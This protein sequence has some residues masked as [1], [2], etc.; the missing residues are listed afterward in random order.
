MF[1]KSR[2]FLLGASAAAFVGSAGHAQEVGSPPAP[3]Q[4]PAQE[5]ADSAAA[6]SA[7]DPIV[8]MGT[9]LRGEVESDIPPEVELG[10]DDIAAYGATSIEEL[11]DALGPQTGSA[12]GRGG[13]GRP[14][15]LLN[16][17]RISGFRELRD[18]PPE[19]IER[20]QVFPEELALEYGYRPDQRVVNFIL[21]ENFA[22]ITGELETGMPTSGGYAEGEIEAT[23]TRITGG[24]RL[25]VDVEY[26]PVTALTEAERDI[27]QD[28]PDEL[29]LV[30]EG[31]F[32]TLI[33]ESDTLEANAS[34]SGQLSPA[35][36]LSLSGEYEHAE[37]R[38]LQGL[39]GADLTVPADSPFAR[40]DEDETV[41]RL[42]PAAGALNRSVNSDSAEAGLALNGSLGDYRWS[43]TGNY[44]RTERET[45]TERQAGTDEIAA[46]V[47]AGDPSVD[48]FDPALGAGLEFTADRTDS[49]TQGADAS[50]NISG[51]P[52]TLPAGDVR[53]SATAGYD[54]Q[55]IEGTS[56]RSGTVTE[57]DLSRS[58]AFIRGNADIPIT[59]VRDDVLAGIGDLSVNLNAG[60]RELSDFGGLTEY[61]YGLRWEPVEDISF[62]ASVIGE[63]AAPSLSQLGDP[64]IV[65]PN[66]R[67]F[68]IARGETVLIDQTTGGNPNLPAEDRRDLK[69]TLNWNPGGER[70]RQFTVEYVRN[71]S[72][73]V[74]SSFPLLT[75]AIEAA[76][77]GRVTRAAD[78]TLIA[79]DARPVAFSE[80][81][82]E[83]LRY[84]INLRGSFGEDEEEGGRGRRGQRGDGPPDPSRM[85]GRGGPSGGRWSFSIFHNWSLEETVLIRDGVPELDL[86]GGDAIAG[87]P[88]ARHSVEAE[89]GVFWNGFGLRADA[90]YTGSARVDG[91]ELPGATDLFYGDLYT[92]D[93][94]LFANLDQQQSLVEAVPFLAG[95]RLSLDIENVFGGIR[96]VEDSTGEVPLSFQPAYLDPQGRFIELSFRK[97]F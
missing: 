25:N 71:H 48:P 75:P 45:V 83:R 28:Q 91:S 34:W 81:D 38:S 19:A 17:Q 26:R 42:F 64:V 82:A 32:R 94:R 54:W 46:A 68:D 16:G 90:N 1:L 39:A 59:S 51:A 56:A 57:T 84:G 53:L 73:N 92:L 22:Q 12:R 14:V 88:I 77:P 40:S 62:L 29:G 30:D 52:V 72:E 69:L 31:E 41:F 70:D 78:G 55:S 67:T 58:T 33:A 50:G 44:S 35:T 9:R 36:S 86:L 80:V 15:I 8:I 87:T 27:V 63:E 2:F 74:A 10:E 23:L 93:L 96:R 21:K 47:L 60:Y 5:E 95:S 13:G 37:S 85:F 61:G 65:T 49:T 18:L 24:G 3:Q 4:V 11:L 97:R 76:F 66:V 7:G 79:L 20:V 43:F 89:G 6:L